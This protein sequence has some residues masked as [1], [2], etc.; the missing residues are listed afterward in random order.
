[1][2]EKDLVDFSYFLNLILSSGLPLMTGLED[3]A[4]QSANK[5]ISFAASAVQAKLETGMSISDAMA[6]YPDLFPHFY[7]SM[8]RAGE[9]SGNLEQVLNGLSIAQPV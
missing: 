3:M 4:A 8:V 5:K 2:S 9:V 6:E 1:M 7:T